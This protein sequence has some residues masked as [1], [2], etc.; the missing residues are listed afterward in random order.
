MTAERRTGER[1]T[2]PE[3]METQPLIIPDGRAPIGVTLDKIL[4]YLA[5]GLIGWLCVTTMSLK[6][7]TTAILEHN[8]A[9]DKRMGSNEKFVSSHEQEIMRIKITMAEHGWKDSGNKERVF[10]PQSS[11]N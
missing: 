7:D 6:Q 3:A 5:T 1:R 2:A 9:M 11:D 4:I 10:A 8:R